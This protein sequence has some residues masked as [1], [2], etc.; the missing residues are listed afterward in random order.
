M[1][2]ASELIGRAHELKPVI[3]ARAL[4]TEHKRSLPDETVKDLCDAGLMQMLTPKRFGGHE[5]HIDTM[6][7]VGRILASACPST[8]WVAAFYIGHNWLHAVFPEQSQVEV[9]ADKPYQLSSGQISPTAKAV[10]V[11]GGYELS[12]RQAWSSGV[13]HSDYVFFTAMVEARMRR[14]RR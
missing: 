1:D 10:K 13:V 11:K 3:A 6:A 7:E 12:G 8:G 9:F 14:R 4:A 5:L 2:L